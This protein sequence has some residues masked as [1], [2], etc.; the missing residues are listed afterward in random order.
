VSEPD[1][2]E[3]YRRWLLELWSGRTE[4]AG[5]IVTD[6]FLVHQARSDGRPPDAVRGPEA[7]IELVQAGRG[8][9]SSIEFAIEVGP[10]V[11]GDLVAA[12]WTSRGV[13]AGGIPGTTAEP[14]T[15][16]SFGGTD[17]FRIR[18]GRFSEYWVS[19]DGLALMT[20]LGA[21]G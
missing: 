6:D 9:F 16:V 17:V 13:Y 18:D 21:F 5:E 7:A 19:S 4:I 3:L 2:R 12:R 15:E 10:L 11:D 1:P 14:G 8:P 20:Q